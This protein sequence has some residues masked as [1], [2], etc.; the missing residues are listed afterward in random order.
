MVSAQPA[1]CTALT[2]VRHMIQAPMSTKTGLTPWMI[3]RFTPV[4]K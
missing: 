4:V 2:G 3:D 1:I